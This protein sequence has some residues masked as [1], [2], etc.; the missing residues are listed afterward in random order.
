M[1][2]IV[3][4]YNEI[5]LSKANISKDISKLAAA[6]VY[7]LPSCNGTWNESLAKTLIYRMLECSAGESLTQGQ[8]DCLTGKLSENLS[9]NCCK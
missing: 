5:E 2:H 7:G 4:D 1:S 3:I 9:V 6:Q 8:V